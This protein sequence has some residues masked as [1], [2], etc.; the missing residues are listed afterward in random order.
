VHVAG[1]SR[2]KETIAR[3]DALIESLADPNHRAML[4]AFRTHWWSEVRGDIDAAMSVLPVD[5]IFK[6]TGAVPS[7]QPFEVHTATEQ[8]AIYE[9]QLEAGLTPAAGSFQDERWA[10]ADWGMMLE[11]EWVFVL[12]GSMICGYGSFEAERLYLVKIPCVAVIPYRGG[13]ILGGEIFYIGNPTSIEP[14]DRAMLEW[15]TAPAD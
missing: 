13:G 5:T 6:A 4:S 3:I 9:V 11:A 14:T 15:L 2:A 10:F 8:R 12:Y 7:G 1:L